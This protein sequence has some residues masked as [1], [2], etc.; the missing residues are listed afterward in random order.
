MALTFGQLK[1]VI[2]NEINHNDLTTE[3]GEAIISAIHEFETERFTFNQAN[4]TSAFTSGDGALAL[5]EGFFSMVSFR[6]TDA[7]TYRTL[8]FMPS[9]TLDALDDNANY[10]GRPEYYTIFSQAIRV[11]PVPDNDYA[12]T[13]SYHRTFDDPVSDSDIHPFITNAE[14]MIK[15]KAKEIIYGDFLLD[16]Q[17]AG[18]YRL[19]AGGPD[20][21]SA[22]GQ[23]VG[24]Y[25]RLKRELDSQSQTYIL[26]IN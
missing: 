14:L 25:G 15:Y 10:M 6:Y 26:N 19:R 17:S 12:V 24:E 23:Y 11:Y 8:Q 3:I 13:F 5:P 9:A 4:A 18:Y 2:A 20:T 16:E 22:T 21:K 7:N 1:T